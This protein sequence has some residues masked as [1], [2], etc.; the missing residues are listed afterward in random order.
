MNIII[1]ALICFSTLMLPLIATAANYKVSMIGTESITGMQWSVT[2]INNKGQVYGSCTEYVPYQNSKQ[3][4]FICDDKN[5][6]ELIDGTDHQ[7]NYYLNPSAANNNGWVVGHW[8]GQSSSFIWSKALGLRAFDVDGYFKSSL[9]KNDTNNFST[10][11]ALNDL[12]QVIGTYYTHSRGNR[13]F[14]WDNGV[15]CEMG[16]GSEFAQQFEEL[17]FHVIDIKLTAINNKGELGGYLQYGKYNEKKKIYVPAGYKTFFWDGVPHILPL[18]SD[19]EA[20]E[21]V[22]LNY[23]GVVLVRIRI[24]D[25]E[26]VHNQ[27]TYLW[28]IENDLQ[29][30]PDFH[31]NTLNDSSIVLGTIRQYTCCREWEE[32]PAIWKEGC[33]ITLAELLGVSNIRNI[34]APY[35][36]SYE[37][38]RIDQV[39]S[40]NNKGQIVCIGCL[41]GESHPCILAPTN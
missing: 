36:E 10:P 4:L 29:I 38:E 20:P 18:P 32:I 2:G 3:S 33:C 6:F 1:S 11:I 31:G 7:K 9:T 24:P 22:K 35:S 19:I 34:A 28:D 15:L 37:I 12:G 13:P 8:N 14:L 25:R 41:W 30:L 16:I 17:G 23:N 27:V 26:N 40:I 5:V 21:V 39:I